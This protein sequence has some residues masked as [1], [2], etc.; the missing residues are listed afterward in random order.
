MASRFGYGS[1][2]IA[3]TDHDS[4]LTIL[5]SVIYP[6][7]TS[8]RLNLETLPTNR[9]K[10]LSLKDSYFFTYLLK[11]TWKIN[12]SNFLSQS[13]LRYWKYLGSCLHWTWTFGSNHHGS[14]LCKSWHNVVL[15]LF[16]YWFIQSWDHWSFLWSEQRYT[17]GQK[18]FPNYL[19]SFDW[20]KNLPYRSWEIIW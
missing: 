7:D 17:V 5:I 6:S 20:S 14:D 19:P 15:C 3:F 13:S 16:H 8:S 4:N 10:Q 9:K 12:E 18:C 11:S 2:I 1:I